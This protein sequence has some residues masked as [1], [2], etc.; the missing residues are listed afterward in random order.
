MKTAIDKCKEREQLK[1]EATVPLEQNLLVPRKLVKKVKHAGLQ[2]DVFTAIE[3]LKKRLGLPTLFTYSEY[4]SKNEK[5]DIELA[6]DVLVKYQNEQTK[7]RLSPILNEEQ[8]EQLDNLL[9]Q[10]LNVKNNL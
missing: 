7:Q 9:E 10:N 8:L 6:I 1:N 3:L 4:V 2:P 5:Q